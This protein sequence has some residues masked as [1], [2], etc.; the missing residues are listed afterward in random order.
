MGELRVICYSI[1]NQSFSKKKVQSKFLFLKDKASRKA[2]IL[3]NSLLSSHKCLHNFS[4]MINF[5]NLFSF[6]VIHS[7][8]N[9]KIKE[10][11]ILKISIINVSY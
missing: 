4:K 7:Y 2:R 9:M 10:N 6:E 5:S 3:N 8:K 1:R 11:K